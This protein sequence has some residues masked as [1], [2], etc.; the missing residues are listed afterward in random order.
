L[1]WITNWVALLLL[2]A[3]LVLLLAQGKATAS[4]VVH[5]PQMAMHLLGVPRL[6]ADEQHLMQ[7]Q[8]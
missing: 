4:L 6:T 5:L 7:Q 8:R 2:L 3:R 1:A